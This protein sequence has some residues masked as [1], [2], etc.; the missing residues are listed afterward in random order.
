[1]K[2]NVSVPDEK[3][4][5]LVNEGFVTLEGTVDWGFQR[6]ARSHARAKSP[7]CAA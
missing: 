7:A 5:A 2:I 4:K 1:M 3:M 6:R